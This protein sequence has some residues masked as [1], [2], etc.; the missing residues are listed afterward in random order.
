MLLAAP[1]GG[2]V[3]GRPGVVPLKGDDFN[4]LAYVLGSGGTCYWPSEGVNKD[5]QVA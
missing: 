1:N 4:K 5:F 2:K 3:V